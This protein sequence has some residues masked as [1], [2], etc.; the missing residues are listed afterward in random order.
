MAR[1]KLHAVRITRGQTESRSVATG[2]CLVGHGRITNSS[3]MGHTTTL[4]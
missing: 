2:T 3:R 4:V 1:E